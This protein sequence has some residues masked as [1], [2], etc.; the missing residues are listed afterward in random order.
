MQR[1]Y[2]ADKPVDHY[3][4]LH[5]LGQGIASRVYLAQDRD[6]HQQVVLKFP[7]DDDATSAMSLK[8]MP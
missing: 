2:Q 1:Y 3:K 6:N 7:L 4:I 8:A 5:L